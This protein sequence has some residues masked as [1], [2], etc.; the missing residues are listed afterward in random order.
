MIR[1]PEA[2]KRYNPRY[3]VSTLGRVRRI[4]KS[5]VTMLKP[6]RHQNKVLVTI[7]YKQKML[8]RVVWETF[9]GRI[10]DGCMVTHVNGCVTM[11]ELYNLRLIDTAGRMRIVNRSKTH[12]ILNID[13]GEVYAS[14]VA[15]SKRLHL[16][17]QTIR[18]YCRHEEA[19]PIYNLEYLKD[20]E[21]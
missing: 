12:R 10:P 20:D 14:A 6:F 1:E 9:N 2:W 11:N 16:H 4:Y 5:R 19:K 21:L 18:S 8:A 17:P 15:A 7:D 3:E 13:T